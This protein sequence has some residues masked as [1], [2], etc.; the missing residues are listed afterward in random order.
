M[1]D[2]LTRGVT[3]REKPV[4]VTAKEFDLLHFLARHP[5][6][7]FTR[8]QLLENVWGLTDYID[9]GTVTVHIRRL[10]EKIESDPSKPVHILTLWGVGYKFE[11]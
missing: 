6:Q 11:A 10:R 4:V 5:R 3:V 2:P 7:V 1:I 9:P 8:E